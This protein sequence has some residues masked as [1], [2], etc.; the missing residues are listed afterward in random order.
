MAGDY[1]K[2]DPFYHSLE[3][4]RVRAAALMRDGGMCQDCM[5]RLRQGVG[6]RPRRAVLVH[7][8]IPRSERPD[9]ELDLNNLRALCATCHEAN[10]PE[11]RQGPRK[12]TREK[13]ERAGRHQMRVV[14]V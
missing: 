2:S 1:K 3:W 14:K 5:D 13:M 4:K 11:R 12:E 7:H 6:I 10:H 8:V 9:L